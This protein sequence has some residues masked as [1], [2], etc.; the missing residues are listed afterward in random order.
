M[1]DAK[2]ATTFECDVL[3]IGS[4]AAGMTAAITAK[5]HGLEPLI[6]EKAPVFG[7][8]TA[9]SGGAA[10]APLNRLAQ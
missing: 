10:W 8:S 3:V 7:G 6:V 1:A 4:G 5:L 2:A 9:V